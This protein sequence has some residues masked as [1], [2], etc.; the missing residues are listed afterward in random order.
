[1]EVKGI[2]ELSEEQVKE[3]IEA[4]VENNIDQNIRT[5]KNSTT[6]KYKYYDVGGV[7]DKRFDGVT[8][9]VNLNG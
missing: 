5:I 3:I 4:H 7:S 8:I 2:I 9:E 1:M 6:P